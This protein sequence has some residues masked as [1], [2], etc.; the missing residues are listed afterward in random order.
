MQAKNYQVP[1]PLKQTAILVLLDALFLWPLSGFSLATV[2]LAVVSLLHI[3]VGVAIATIWAG[4]PAGRTGRQ[5]ALYYLL[6]LLSMLAGRGV[7]FLVW[8]WAVAM[9]AFF[10]PAQPVS[11]QTTENPPPPAAS[12][13]PVYGMLFLLAGAL[14]LLGLQ[15]GFQTTEF[16]PLGMLFV[17]IAA[18]MLLIVIPFPLRFLACDEARLLVARLQYCLYLLLVLIW[19]VFLFRASA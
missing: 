14:L 9:L 3:G 5:K 11:E 12:F 17:N 2:P 15:Y 16:G 4:T 1:E 13:W 18:S 10:S 6:F 7:G 8:L 19:L